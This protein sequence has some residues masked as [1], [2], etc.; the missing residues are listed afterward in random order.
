M[1]GH[2]KIRRQNYQQ[3]LTSSQKASREDVDEEETE[4]FVVTDMR[5]KNHHFITHRK[6]SDG[7]LVG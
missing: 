6:I 4:S 2:N 5:D 7:I 3:E 1:T